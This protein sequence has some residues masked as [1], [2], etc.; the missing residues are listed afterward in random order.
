MVRNDQFPCSKKTPEN[1]LTLYNGEEGLHFLRI[2][3]KILQELCVETRNRY[4]NGRN[5]KSGLSA[6]S[7][8]IV[9]LRLTERFT[10]KGL[11]LLAKKRWYQICHLRNFI[12]FH[13][14]WVR[15]SMHFNILILAIKLIKRY[16]IQY[17]F[18]VDLEEHNM[19]FWK[20]NT[21]C[22]YN[23]SFYM[24]FIKAQFTKEKTFKRNCAITLIVI[25]LLW[26]FICK[27]KFWEK[28]QNHL[29]HRSF[30]VFLLSDAWET[31]NVQ[32]SSR[33]YEHVQ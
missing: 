3:V 17:Q 27:K 7:C 20:S 11:Q 9:S 19:C 13:H 18:A 1:S 23:Y 31:P 26:N 32:H 16:A 15:K 28:T 12:S 2:T 6:N 14:K 29:L 21:A 24:H 10:S 22:R 30:I 33:L 25:L 5:D 8:P 4:M